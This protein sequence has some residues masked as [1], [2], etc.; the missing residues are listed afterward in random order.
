M[1]R[2]VK[3]EGSGLVGEVR[4]AGLRSELRWPSG[5]GLD[6]GSPRRG[7]E[8]IEGRPRHCSCPLVGFGEPGGLLGARGMHGSPMETPSGRWKD[9]GS[10]SVC[11]GL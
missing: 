11:L 10:G 7:G 8:R 1:E 4:G 3:R 9:V 5:H 6:P 2:G